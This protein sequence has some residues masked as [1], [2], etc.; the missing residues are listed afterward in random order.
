MLLRQAYRAVSFFKDNVLMRAIICQKLQDG[1]YFYGFVLFF[2]SVFMFN[3]LAFKLQK[4][5]LALSELLL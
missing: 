2:L 4:L 3:P 5:E 1:K